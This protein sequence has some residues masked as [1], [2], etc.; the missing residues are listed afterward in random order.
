MTTKIDRTFNGLRNALFDEI[1]A[2]RE[3][4][5]NYEQARAIVQASAQINETVHAEA[6]VRKMIGAPASENDR[7]GGLLK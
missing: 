5:G 2:M 1:D 3:G 6:K 4:R 7:L